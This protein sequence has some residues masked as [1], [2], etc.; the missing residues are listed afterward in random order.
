[1]PS[2]ASAIELKATTLGMFGS[3]AMMATGCLLLARSSTCLLG[4]SPSTKSLYGPPNEVKRLADGSGHDP[5]ARG[6]CSCPV[7]NSTD[8]FVVGKSIADVDEWRF[9]RGEMQKMRVSVD[10]SRQDGGAPQVQSLDRFRR[11]VVL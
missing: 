4:N 10:Q 2:A 6:R 11:W 5:L 1:M 9:S 7:C 3:Q 8:D